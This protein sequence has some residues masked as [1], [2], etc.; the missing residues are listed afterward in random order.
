MARGVG[1]ESPTSLTVLGAKEFR[2]GEAAVIG[3]VAWLNFHQKASMGLKL[4]LGYFLD[5]A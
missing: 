2:E 3:K 4:G 5:A 1:V